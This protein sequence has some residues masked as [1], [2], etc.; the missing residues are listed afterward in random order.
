MPPTLKL[1]CLSTAPLLQLRASRFLS[2][3][4]FVLRQNIGQNLKKG[5]IPRCLKKKA[6]YSFLSLDYLFPFT[7]TL[8]VHERAQQT[9]EE[10]ARATMKRVGLSV[11]PTKISTPALSIVLSFVQEAPC[12]SI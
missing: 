6:G 7:F 12:G 3:T 8:S 5:G 11:L 4:I 1:C 2:R 10:I 9:G